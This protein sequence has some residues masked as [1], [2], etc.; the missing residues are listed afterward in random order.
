MLC[1]RLPLNVKCTLLFAQLKFIIV[2]W[3][4]M[5]MWLTSVILGSRV[6]SSRAVEPKCMTRKEVFNWWSIVET[7]WKPPSD[8]PGSRILILIPGVCK[9]TIHSKKWC[10]TGCGPQREIFMTKGSR[11]LFPDS[12]SALNYPG[13]TQNDVYEQCHEQMNKIVLKTVINFW[14]TLTYIF[15]YYFIL[16]HR[17]PCLINKLTSW[18]VE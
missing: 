3:P 5:A 17:N 1:W 16:C 18:S 9:S 15:K 12:R 11:T 8:C 14:T 4:F 6:L 7:S 10:Q 2:W 13:I